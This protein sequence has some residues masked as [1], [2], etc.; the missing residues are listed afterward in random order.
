MKVLEL[1][2]S[3]SAGVAEFAEVIST[4]PALTAKVLALANS[5]AFS[6]QSPVTRLSVAIGMIGLRNLLPL[7][8]GLSFAGIFNKFS[9][10]AA[11]R[12]SLW[13]AAVLKAVLARQTVRRLSTVPAADPRRSEEE[14]TAF[15]AGLL[16]D[17]VLPVL[18][19]TDK[20]SWAHYLAA[21]DAP[22]EQR[23]REEVRVFGIGHAELAGR[24]ARMLGL[25]AFFSSACEVH[26]NGVEALQAF[27]TEAQA[28]AM[29]AAAVIPHRLI[30]PMPKVL[31]SV[32]TRLHSTAGLS[33]TVAVDVI[34]NTAEEYQRLMALFSEP[35]ETSPSFKEFLQNLSTEVAQCMQGAIGHNATQISTLKSREQ[36]MRNEIQR[37]QERAQQAEFDPLT[38]VLT[39]KALLARL[40]N[41]L[42]LGRQYGAPC[43]LGFVDIDNFKGVNDTYGHAVGDAAL[44][45]VSTALSNCLAGRGIIG[46]YGGDEFVFAF[47]ARDVATL[48][49]EAAACIESVSRIE[50][51]DAA[52]RVGLTTSVGVITVGVP[53]PEMDPLCMM[54]EA[55]AV[56]YRAKRNGKARGFIH[57]LGEPTVAQSVGDRRLEAPQTP[58]TQAPNATDMPNVTNVPSAI[59]VPSA[60]RPRPGTSVAGTGMRLTEKLYRQIITRLKSEKSRGRAVERRRLARVGLRVQVILLPCR[61]DQQVPRDI[62]LRDMSSEGIGFVFPE[63]LARGGYVLMGFPGGGK[64]QVQ[65]LYRIM[66]CHPLGQDQYSIG[67]R[68][69]R[70]ISIEEQANLDL[71]KIERDPP[72]SAVDA[73]TVV[74]SSHAR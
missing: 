69:E 30:V 10:P 17:I 11:D 20:S 45:K 16:Q 33:P 13:R 62:W 72:H 57:R 67:A 1:K 44:I 5:A 60:A 24:C 43:A 56:M 73:G 49:A 29:D 31:K 9:L 8:F 74:S 71:E 50:L 55:D 15:F 35:E 51:S 34:G 47:A 14:D 19:G 2:R 48:E 25:P 53:P 4:D 3:L 23:L 59:Q 38:H 46:R 12:A 42:D 40:A 64:M 7:V 41:L 70:E 66:R 21:I 54:E 65:I 6:P 52:T 58:T 63:P 61:R 39:R 26:H 37:L 36:D 27:A 22:E 28:L 32:A 68:F 18:Y